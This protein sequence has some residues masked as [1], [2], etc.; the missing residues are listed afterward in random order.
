MNLTNVFLIFRREVRDQLRDRRMLFMMFILPLLL[1]PLM[2]ISWMQL[3]QFLKQHVARV[4]VIG[5]PKLKEYPPLLK[6]GTINP[7]WMKDL[8]EIELHLEPLPPGVTKLP[9]EQIEDARRRVNDQEYDVVVAFPP[10]FAAELQ[11]F[12]Q[13]LLANRAGAGNGEIELHMLVVVKGKRTHAVANRYAQ[14][15]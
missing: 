1:Y 11:A 15:F 14:R 12:H 7:E 8:G 2:G 6:D 3:T 13:W 4:L 10:T 5:A 9:A